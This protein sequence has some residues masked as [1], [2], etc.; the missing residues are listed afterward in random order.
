MKLL[1]DMGHGDV[2]IIADANFP[3]VALC[4]RVVNLNG[5]ETTELLEAVLRFFP[6]DD[7]VEHPVVLMRPGPSEKKPEIWDKYE[8][9]VRENDVIGA[10]REFLLL[11]RVDYYEF[12][13]KSFAVV[14]TGTV[15]R[16]AN[17]ALQKGVVD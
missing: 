11:D 14:Q 13:K 7:F 4:K 12:A 8:A 17:I 15:A 16:Y 6:L 5:V 1:M 9:A 2:I 10:F 3:G